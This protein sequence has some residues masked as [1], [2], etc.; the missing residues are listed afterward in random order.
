MA[1][2]MFTKMINKNRFYGRLSFNCQTYEIHDE[3]LII[4]MKN[5]NFYARI[6]TFLY[7]G[8]VALSCGL[9]LCVKMR[10]NL[11]SSVPQLAT[12]A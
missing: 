10:M 9:L 7:S 3:T 12:P 1:F 6:I 8:N 11:P 2:I 5:I 4:D